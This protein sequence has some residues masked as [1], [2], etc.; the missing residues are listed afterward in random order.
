MA[1]N[2]NHSSP[3]AIVADGLA[4]AEINGLVVDKVMGL[5]PQEQGKR[6][7]ITLDTMIGLDP[8]MLAIEDSASGLIKEGFDIGRVRAIMRE[9][10]Q[11]E[12]NLLETLGNAIADRILG[13]AGAKTVRVSVRKDRTWADAETIRMTISKSV[14]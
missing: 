7:R 14:T 6:Q 9:E 3:P 11:R 8:S 13:L 5:L 10:A 1:P 12:V 4:Y 2:L